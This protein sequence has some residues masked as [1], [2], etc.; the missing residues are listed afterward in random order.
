M[1]NG[2]CVMTE[3]T[4]AA[5]REQLVYD[6]VV[7]GAGIAGLSAALSLDPKLSVAIVNKG[8]P[9]ASSTYRAQGGV[10]AAVGPDDSPEAHSRDTLRV[11]QGLCRREA[12]EVMAREG[13]AA[14]AYLQSLGVDFNR[15]DDELS[16]TK[17]AGHSTKRV[18]HYYDATGRRI[19][20]ALSMEALLRQNI[21]KLHGSFLVD[22]LMED[23][24]CRGCIIWHDGCLQLVRAHTVIIATGGYSGI[25]GRTTNHTSI[26][27]DGIAAAYRAGAAVADMEF[28]QFHPTAFTTKSGEVFLLTEALR[29][30]GA[31]LRNTAGERFMRNYHPDGELAPRD[32]VSRAIATE[33][34]DK[35]QK[36]VYLDARKLGKDY[37]A[38]RFR[39]V[40]TKLAENDYFMERDLIPIAPA[41]H[42]SIGGILTDLWAKTTIPN[43]YACGETAATGV[44]GANRLASNSLL[45]GIVFG[46]RAAQDINGKYMGGGNFTKIPPIQRSGV[47]YIT[48]ARELEIALDAA[49]GV[50]RRGPDMVKLLNRIRE[51]VG[52]AAGYNDLNRHET[53][54]ACQLAILLLQAALFRKESRGTH[55]RADYPEKDEKFAGKH[56]VQRLGEELEL[57]E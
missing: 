42:Y 2:C 49:A 10:S 41:A 46:R 19:S 31:V 9:E 48:D 57:D 47:Q 45:E 29:G 34:R 33:M 38:D 4:E 13:P 22:L 15:Q 36:N 37:L 18:V 43:L 1:S 32:E 39:Q 54:N 35:G 55:F 26:T 40:Y 20:E 12:V 28:V 53:H 44:H 11:G 16:L 17:E 14:I 51:N 56:I 30:E 50:V 8:E 3:N 6:V 7:I 52:H 24:L 21:D 23:G 25:F 27:G 5:V